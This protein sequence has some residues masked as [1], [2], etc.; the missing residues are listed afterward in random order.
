MHYS[1]STGGFYLPDVHGDRMPKDAIGI[2]DKLYRELLNGQSKGGMIVAD[3]FGMPKLV[4]RPG[5]TEKQLTDWARAVRDEK[6]AASDWTQFADAPL[7]P[8]KKAAWTEYR[9]ALRDVTMQAGFPNS[10]TWPS[11]PN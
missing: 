7:S 1:K 2:P 11:A 8:A 4:A 6:L 3:D 9:Q 5:P 10:V